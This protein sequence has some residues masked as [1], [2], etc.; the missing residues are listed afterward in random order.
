MCGYRKGTWPQSWAPRMNPTLRPA[1]A[2]RP[3]SF[4][5][6]PQC[7]VAGALLG[8]AAAGL[9]ACLRCVPA[10]YVW[11]HAILGVSL[12]HR[13]LGGGGAGGRWEREAMPCVAMVFCQSKP[14]TRLSPGVYSVHASLGL[15]KSSANCPLAPCPRLSVLACLL[16]DIGGLAVLGVCGDRP[17][18]LALLWVL[19]CSLSQRVVLVCK[20]G[21][22]VVVLWWFAAVRK[23]VRFT[24]SWAVC[25]VRC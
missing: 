20:Q 25:S 2:L 16:V 12:P 14:G 5:V 3:V 24:W 18:N 8:F 15:H 1:R 21:G 22:L 9:C 10:C 6:C 13:M 17:Q 11:T 4:H 23:H 19:D 7:R